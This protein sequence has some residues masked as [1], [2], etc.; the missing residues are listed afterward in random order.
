MFQTD[1]GLRISRNVLLL[2][3]LEYIPFPL[4]MLQH[5]VYLA[6][7]NMKTQLKIDINRN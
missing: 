1:L 5:N 6:S 2:T 4:V 3:M 7:T